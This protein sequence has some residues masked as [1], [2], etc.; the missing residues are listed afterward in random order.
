MRAAHCQAASAA[1]APGDAPP[2]GEMLGGWGRGDNR[3]DLCGLSLLQHDWSSHNCLLVPCCSVD[4]IFARV[5]SPS[6][7]LLD[8]A[9]GSASSACV[10]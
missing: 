4:D 6:Q 1:G 2:P 8:A 5:L 10:L 3:P 7:L 9:V